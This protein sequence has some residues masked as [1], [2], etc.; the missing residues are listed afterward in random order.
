MARPR[1]E[2]CERLTVGQL[3][4]TVAPDAAAVTLADGQTLALQWAPV[5]GCYGGRG[6]AL[7]AGCPCCA[8]WCRV[9]W[10]PPGN[11]WGC[12]RCKP[13][14]HPSHRRPGGR[15]RKPPGWH[16][17][18][19]EATQTRTAALLGVAWP[20][21]GLPVAWGMDDLVRVTCRPGGPRLSLERRA[22]LLQR[23]SALETLRLSV[24]LPGVCAGLEALGAEAPSLGRLGVV[25]ELARETVR[26][27]GWA[28]RRPGRNRHH[29]WW[30]TPGRR[31]EA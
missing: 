1:A 21:P 9:L 28:V 24:V 18:R 3:R 31:W 2:S 22:A 4:R 25:T 8:R 14:S 5:E 13:V 17:A 23:L 11:G 16:A 7:L 12:W 15:N 20:P 6:H 27:T 26:A 30:H 10:R 29:R 19:I